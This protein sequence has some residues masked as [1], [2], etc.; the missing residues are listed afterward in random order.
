MGSNF[1][2]CKDIDS[3]FIS[4]DVGSESGLDGAL[5][6]IFG[7]LEISDYLQEIHLHSATI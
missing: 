3:V 2:V 7:I 6:I 1:R 5:N 4:P